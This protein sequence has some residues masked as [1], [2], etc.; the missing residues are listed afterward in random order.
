[1]ANGPVP[2]PQ[3]EAAELSDLLLQFSMSIDQIRMDNTDLSDADA[4]RLGTISRQLDELSDELNAEA[5]GQIL[6]N[7]QGNVDNIIQTTKDAEDAIKKAK[8]IERTFSIAGAALTFAAS[9][10]S[11]NPS[12]IISAAAGLASAAAGTAV[13]GGGNRSPAGSA[14]SQTSDS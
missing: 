7:I 12:T 2:T 4:Q 9:F 1:M 3:N 11:G 6:Q 8:N 13:Q 5:I 14:G 10:I